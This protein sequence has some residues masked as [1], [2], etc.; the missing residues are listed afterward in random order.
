MKLRLKKAVS[1]KNKYR[2]KIDS[3]DETADETIF[4][5]DLSTHQKGW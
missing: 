5:I 2:C 3:P 1:M 4:R